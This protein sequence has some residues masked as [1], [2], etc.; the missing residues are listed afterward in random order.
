MKYIELSKGKQAIIDDEDY[1]RVSQYKW[2][3]LHK[4][5]AS[6]RSK[7]YSAVRTTKEHYN[8]SMHRFVLNVPNSFLIPLASTK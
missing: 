3:A 1:E 4:W 8:L 7:T 5:F 6:D 2:H